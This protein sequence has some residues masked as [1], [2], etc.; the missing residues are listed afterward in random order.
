MNVELKNIPPDQRS[1]SQNKSAYGSDQIE[2][3]LK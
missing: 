3:M 1:I 2:P